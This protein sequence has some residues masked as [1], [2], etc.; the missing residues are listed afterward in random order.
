MH[1]ANGSAMIKPTDLSTS[2]TQKSTIKKLFLFLI[3]GLP[4]FLVAVALNIIF[5]EYLAL[6]KWIAYAIVLFIQVTINFFALIAFVFNRDRTKSLGRLYL[7]FL[8]GISVARLL[9]WSVYFVLTGFWGLN[10]VVVQVFNVVLFSV[11]KFIFSRQALER[12]IN[13]PSKS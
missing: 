6:S 7:V 9:D 11:L 13:F 12:T 1:L 2:V 3:V 10:Y 4:G 8:S 5:V